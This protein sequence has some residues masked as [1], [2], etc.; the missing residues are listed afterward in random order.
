M[1]GH[2]ACKYVI[3]GNEAISFPFCIMRHLANPFLPVIAGSE[4]SDYVIAR[5]EAI[6]LYQIKN[7]LF[8]K[9]TKTIE[10]M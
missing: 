9:K 1:Q 4:A 8:F 5:N 3:A 2:E 6:S 10:L 7:P